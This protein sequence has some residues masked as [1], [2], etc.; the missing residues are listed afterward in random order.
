MKESVIKLDLKPKENKNPETQS[1]TLASLC[2]VNIPT[3]A[4][5]KLPMDLRLLESAL[6]D[7]SPQKS[8][9]GFFE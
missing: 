7:S 2:G 6:A 9:I 5:F 4:N 3:M 1:L 8:L